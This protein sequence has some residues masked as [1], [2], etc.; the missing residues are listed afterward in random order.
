MSACA[1]SPPRSPEAARR[2]RGRARDGDRGRRGVVLIM[3][4]WTLVLLATLAASVIYGSRTELRISRNAVEQA[5]ARALAEAGI[6]YGIAKLLERGAADPWPI[7]G[8]P[9][10]FTGQ[11]AHPFLIGE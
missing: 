8:T 2:A 5:Q 11:P 7:D 1:P 3:A 4:L 6:A 10:R 9:R